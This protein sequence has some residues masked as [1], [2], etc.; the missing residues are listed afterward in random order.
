MA[1]QLDRLIERDILEANDN[2]RGKRRSHK[3]P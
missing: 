3:P 2:A 1:G